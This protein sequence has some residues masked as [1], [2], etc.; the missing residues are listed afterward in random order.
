M[1]IS[2]TEL[3]QDT[4]GCDGLKKLKCVDFQAE[5]VSEFIKKIPLMLTF[6]LPLFGFIFIDKCNIMNSASPSDKL[7]ESNNLLQL[8]G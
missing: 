3:F 6:P 7:A 1:N 5:K 4:R 8:W 2:I